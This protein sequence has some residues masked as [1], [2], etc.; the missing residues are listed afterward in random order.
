MFQIH[1]QIQNSLL[2]LITHWYYNNR[3]T[4]NKINSIPFTVELYNIYTRLMNT[5][6]HEYHQTYL[7]H[8]TILFNQL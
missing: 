5:L 4:N 8:V 6:K 1:I 7:K 3:V 2:S